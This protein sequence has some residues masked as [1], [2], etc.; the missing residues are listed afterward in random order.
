MKR[1]KEIIS[2]NLAGKKVLLLFVITNIIYAIMLVVTI[3]ET[4]TFSN[5]MKLL[6][7]MPTGYDSEYVHALFETLGV[8]GRDFYLYKQIRLI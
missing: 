1:I 7:M 8:K 3:P 4:M 5:G 2:K 6:D